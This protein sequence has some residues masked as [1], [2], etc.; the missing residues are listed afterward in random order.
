MTHSH[1]DRE[2]LATSNVITGRGARRG[3][4]LYT[5]IDEGQVKRQDRSL[6]VTANG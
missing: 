1:G 5:P 2:V 4:I 6:A 3:C